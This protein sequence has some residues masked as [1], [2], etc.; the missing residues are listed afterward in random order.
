MW[1]R[2]SSRI[3]VLAVRGGGGGGEGKSRAS[4]RRSQEVIR[5]SSWYVAAALRTPPRPPRKNERFNNAWVVNHGICDSLDLRKRF[6]WFDGFPAPRCACPVDVPVRTY[7][8]QGT[9]TWILIKY[10]LLSALRPTGTPNG[11]P[12]FRVSLCFGRA[13]LSVFLVF[14]CLLRARVL[15]PPFSRRVVLVRCGRIFFKRG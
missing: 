5:R 4:R 14:F 2:L 8:A 1:L 9:M 6:G 12:V 13:S 10:L 7:V 3:R 11:A 15:C